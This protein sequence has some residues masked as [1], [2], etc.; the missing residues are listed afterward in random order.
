MHI[1]PSGLQKTIGVFTKN[2]LT[3]ISINN[4]QKRLRAN[5]IIEDFI[6]NPF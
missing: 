6:N 1:P 3:N 4:K 5:T 2:N